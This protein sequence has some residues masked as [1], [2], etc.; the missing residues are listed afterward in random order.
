[1]RRQ[2][3]LRRI[4]LILWREYEQRVRSRSFLVMTFLLPLIFA[5]IA[6]LPKFLVAK[7]LVA[8]A[9]TTHRTL[10]LAIVSN[11]A[12]L[13]AAIQTELSS[14]YAGQFS[15][16]LTASPSHEMRANLDTWI[17][18]HRL[19]GYLWITVS[20]SSR[21]NV[22]FAR[23]DTL[24]SG[25]SQD[26]NRAV[27]FAFVARNLIP[28]GISTERA[29]ALLAPI[30]FH[31]AS[32]NPSTSH[33]RS[34]VAIAIIGVMTIVMFI[35]LLSYGIMVMRAVLDE[36][37]SRITEVLLCSTSAAELMAGKVIGIG[38]LGLTQVA[39]WFAIGA[40]LV[41]ESHSGH[42]AIFA[43]HEATPAIIWFVIFYV[44]GYLLYSSIYAGV[45]AAFN[46]MDDAQQWT[47]VILLPLV[48]A[49]FLIGPAVTA[50]G[51]G[52]VVAASLIPF[53]SPVLMYTRILMD[54][55]PIWQ[56]ALSI[57]ILIATVWIALSIS[58]RIYRVGILMYGKR[59]TLGE[60]VRWLR[61]A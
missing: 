20:G 36:K 42:A 28:S 24:P 38:A 37:S 3:S 35:S 46:S 15:V 58:A 29:R 9:P 6:V 33:V 34:E 12:A 26:I 8:S 18:E 7:D 30:D 59:P 10:R 2:G 32:V 31:V 47:Y 53:T 52:A 48:A 16:A 22:V 21:P 27:W 13:G 14:R 61:Y 49:S 4:A 41:L 40:G 56:V 45:G 51:S 5:A 43:S 54:S 1:M 55:P 60:I 11:V 57:A 50:T 19:D 23:P 44:L 39:V 25:V 17:R